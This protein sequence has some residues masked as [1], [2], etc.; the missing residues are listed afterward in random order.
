MEVDS[1][2]SDVNKFEEWLET[3]DSESS[4]SFNE[5][6]ITE[7]A[8][9]LEH[10]QTQKKTK[11]AKKWITSESV[12]NNDSSKIGDWLVVKFSLSMSDKVTNITILFFNRCPFKK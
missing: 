11:L 10:R 12:E 1:T 9:W 2:E 7:I 6:E 3:N 5:G 8:E 4:D